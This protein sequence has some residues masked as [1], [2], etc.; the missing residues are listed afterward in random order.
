MEKNWTRSKI[1]KKRTKL[2][3]DRE[4]RTKAIEKKESYRWIEGV[5]AAREVAEACPRTTCA[6]IC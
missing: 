4:N 6:C 3:R 5:R 2:E 1:M